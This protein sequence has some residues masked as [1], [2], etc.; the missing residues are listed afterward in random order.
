MDSLAQSLKASPEVYPHAL[1]PIGDAVS[2]IRMPR[3]A[4]AAASFLDGRLL[5]PQTE[6]G[7]RPWAQVEAAAAEARLGAHC[8]F[9]FHIGHVG[10]TLMSRL[11]EASPAL[12]ALREPQT[13]RTLAQAHAELAEPESLWSAHDFERRLAVFMQLWSRVFAPGQ[14]TVVKATSLCCGM[15][16]DLLAR[17][18]RPRG[19]FMFT[20]PDVYLA[21]LLG[22]A[23]N[24]IDIRSMAS[25]RLRRLHRRIGGPAWRLSELSY[26]EMAAMSW[27]CEMTAL[28]AAAEAHG[29]RILWIDFERFLARPQSGLATAFAH[30]GA[31]T[32]PD[33][34]ASIVAGPEMRRY[35]KAPEHAYDA[36]LRAR[37]LAQAR[38]TGRQEIRA[39][40]DW[41]DAAAA[42]F[43]PIAAAVDLSARR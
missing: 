31:E 40:L 43:A 8:Q 17:P 5:T 42:R 23:N 1:D 20:A 13:L 30:L 38:E 3:E 18:S 35:S 27:A 39:G 25:A 26:G 4:F 32:G 16:A 28:G 14:T 22:G 21:T 2:F 19:L 24:H 9:I 10:S 6:V 7:W 36:A 12:L 37:V 11:L 15:A 41:L 34:I 29:D 33:E